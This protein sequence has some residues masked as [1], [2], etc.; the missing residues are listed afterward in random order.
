MRSKAVVASSLVGE[1]GYDVSDGGCVHTH[2]ARQELTP[3]ERF[4]E[5]KQRLAVEEANRDDV[6]AAAQAALDFQARYPD[7]LN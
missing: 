7:S 6:L 3:K 4:A 1:A 2:Q 5:D